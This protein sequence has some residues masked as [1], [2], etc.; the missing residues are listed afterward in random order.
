MTLIYL[1]AGHGGRDSG[2]TGNGIAEKDIVLDIC[3]RIE[4]GLKS[5]DCRVMQSRTTDTFL[6]LA[7]RTT[8]ANNARA[9]VFVSVHCNAFTNNT[10]RGFET[11]RHTNTPA[12]TVSFQ[13]VLHEEIMKAIS[14]NNIPDRGKKQANFHV[15][16]ESNMSACLTECLFVSNPTEARL[17]ADASFRQ[18]LAQGHIDGLVKFLGLRRIERPPETPSNDKLFRVQVGAFAERRNAEALAADLQRQG[19]RTLITH[20]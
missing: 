3:K 12:R 5:F 16:R 14:G 11:F 4:A 15:L 20:S 8:R 10:A 7:E 18:R 9:D 13:N 1:D 19:Y 6:T 2:A 17:L